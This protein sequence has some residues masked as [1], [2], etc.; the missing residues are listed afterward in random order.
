MATIAGELRRWTDKLERLDISWLLQHV[1]DVNAAFLVA[2]PDYLLTAEQT[3]AFHELMTKRAAGVPVAYLTGKQGFY[4]LIF[5][6]TSDVLIPRPETELLIETVLAMI[7]VNHPCNILDLGTG[8]GAIAITIARHRPH[9]HVFALDISINALLLARRNAGRLSVSNI[10]FVA[11]NWYAALGAIRFDGIVANPPYI[12]SAD[13]HLQQGDLR[14]EPMLALV[15]EHDGLSCL[16]KII[17]QAPQFLHQGGWLLFEH[18]YDQAAACRQLLTAAGFT[19]LIRQSDFAQI[20]RVSG[21]YC[22]SIFR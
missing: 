9:V 17:S 12:A 4:D 10:D 14:F 19:E 20:D 6:V 8:S 3:Q 11:S 21:G 18:G 2:H 13:P 5:E 22:Q 15:A 1:L 16:R 7:P